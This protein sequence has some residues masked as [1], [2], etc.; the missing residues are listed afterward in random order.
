MQEV[1]M[2][3]VR[4]REYETDALAQGFDWVARRYG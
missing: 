1:V 3:A 4:F 2:G